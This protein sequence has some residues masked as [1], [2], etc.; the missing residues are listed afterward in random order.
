M[1]SPWLMIVTTTLGTTAP[2]ASVTEPRIVP[3]MVCPSPSVARHTATNAMLNAI[4]KGLNFIGNPPSPHA[5]PFTATHETGFIRKIGRSICHKCVESQDEKNALPVFRCKLA[6]LYGTG[7]ERVAVDHIAG[8]IC[9]DSL[10]GPSTGR[11]APSQHRAHYP[12]H[13]PRRSHGFPWVW[14]WAYAKSGRIGPPVRGFFPCLRPRAADY[15]LARHHPHRNLPAVQSRE[16]HGRTIGQGAPVP[17]R[18]PAQERIQDRCI[19]GSTGARPQETCA[20]FRPGL[21]YLR[22]GI[23]SATPKRGP[24]P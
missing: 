20:R 9:H 1:F 21:R 16:L 23:S 13:H 6:F 15:A 4:T 8:R 17:A 5:A 22:R 12:A 14:T 2:D 19:C 10:S 24:L 3:K 7:K 11:L 18:H